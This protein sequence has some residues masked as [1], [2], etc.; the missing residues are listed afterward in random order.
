V[1][2]RTVVITGG[3][4]F[5]GV[6]AAEAFVRDGWHVVVFDNLSRPGSDLNL[7]YLRQKFPRECE[8][9]RGDV[10]YDSIALLHTIARA[11]LILHLAAQVAVTTSIARPLEDFEI[12]ARGTLN[13]LEAVR[14]SGNKPLLVYSSTNKVYGAMPE[15]ACVKDGTRY[16]FRDFSHGISEDRPLDFHSPYGCSK[17]V[18]DQYVHDYGRIYGIPT[19]VF[20]QSCIYGQ[21]QFGVEDQG[22]VAWFA[23]AALVQRPITI[24][25]DGL[26]MRDVLHVND[27]VAA[28]KKA[29]QN[30][31]RAVGKIFNIGGGSSRT[32]SL[33]ELL[34]L[35]EDRLQRRIPVKHAPSRAGDQPVFVAD[36]RKAERELQW[37]PAIDPLPG[38][39]ML[40]EWIQRNLACV[41]G[42]LE[43]VP[44]LR[45]QPPAAEVGIGPTDSFALQ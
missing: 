2:A 32:L 24:Y 18:A 38:V 41:Q 9:I 12:N 37:R 39:E 8:F 22:W 43:T 7:Q 4:G 30:P 19:V 27:L 26:Q 3:A 20:R 44:L 28:Y 5:I 14:A 36:I 6:N 34:N 21:R 15:V 11:Q 17:G 10:R 16:R 40:L 42:V 33:L 1:A 31:E 35:L 25:G 45:E 29:A 23:I 13:V